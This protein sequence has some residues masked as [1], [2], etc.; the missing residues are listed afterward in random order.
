MERFDQV[1]AS[2]V[3]FR[4]DCVLGTIANRMNAF[5]GDILICHST[6]EYKVLHSNRGAVCGFRATCFDVIEDEYFK[7]AI[8]NKEKNNLYEWIMNVKADKEGVIVVRLYET[9]KKNKEMCFKLT[10]LFTQTCEEEER[11][12]KVFREGE[13]YKADRIEY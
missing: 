5:A 10:S 11:V 13:G 8:K 12:Y 1:L 2:E 4:M 6:I 3:K 7:D 9:T